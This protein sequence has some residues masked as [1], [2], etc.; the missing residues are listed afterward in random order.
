MPVFEP[1]SAEELAEGL[2]SAASRSQTIAIAGHNTKK[3]MAGPIKPADLTISTSRLNRILQYERGDLTISVGAGLPFAELQHFLSGY[4]QM[5]AL[6]PPFS[7]QAT[8][9][10]VLAANCSGP[11]RRGFGSARDLVI[12]LS[13]A[14]LKGKIVNSGGMVV[15][16]V[17]G[18]D[19]G[20]LLLGSFGTLAVITSANFRVHSLPPETRTFLFAFN[21]LDAVMLKRNLILKGGLQP[22]AMD[23]LSPAAATRLS[24]RGY[25]LAVRAGGSSAVLA[26]YA[27]DL[28]G[29]DNLK[30]DE[31]SRFWEQVREFTPDFLRRQPSGIVLRISTSLAE[32]ESVVRSASGPCISRAGS[33]VTYV[34]LTGWHGLAPVWTT[35]GE[36]GWSVAV[37]FAPDNIRET[38]ELWLDRDR[39]HSASTFALMTKIKEMFDPE[40]LL[41]AGRLYGRI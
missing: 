7:S 5:I 15:K 24:R 16:N 4:G 41:N 13:F 36:K 11:M 10:G 25:L 12:G 1:G 28:D 29:S 18:L 39:S 34:N 9:G 40:K 19:M 3:L 6:D 38:K 22:M 27:R 31:D 2:R 32:I 33:G 21:D 8:V 26:R 23:I 30:G 35:A 14:T 20:K 17:A 37:E